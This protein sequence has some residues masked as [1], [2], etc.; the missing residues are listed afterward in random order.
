MIMCDASSFLTYENITSIGLLLFAVYYLA[1]KVDKLE[2]ALN[3]E[4]ND[5]FEISMKVYELTTELIN[6]LKN[7]PKKDK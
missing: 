7:G 4:R 2:G 3:D 5:K 6:Q 1:R